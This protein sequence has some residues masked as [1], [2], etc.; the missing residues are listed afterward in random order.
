LATE[1][2]IALATLRARVLDYLRNEIAGWSM[3][4]VHASLFGSAARGD[5]GTASDIDLLVLH[6]QFSSPGE[7]Q[8][9]DDQ[10]ALS[11]EAI[12][13]GT[14]NWLGWF[15]ISEAG[16]SRMVTEQQPIVED[17]RRD[18][19]TLVGRPL[20]DLLRTVT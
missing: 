14:G 19:I 13:R 3:P 10:L 5:G 9:W 17:W 6:Q 11:G 15:Q 20:I 18:A 2:A 12:H 4:A 16:L 8:A 7:Q 1:P